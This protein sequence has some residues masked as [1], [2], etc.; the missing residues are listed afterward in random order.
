VKTLPLLQRYVGQVLGV[1]RLF[2]DHQPAVHSK[3]ESLLRVSAST[4][5]ETNPYLEP[6]VGPSLSPK[7]SREASP[8]PGEVVSAG[9]A[10]AP[11]GLFYFLDSN[12]EQADLLTKMLAAMDRPSACEAVNLQTNSQFQA[13]TQLNLI[14]GEAAYERLTN[15]MGPTYEQAYGIVQTFREKR[16]LTTSGP[17]ELLKDPA[18]KRA[19]W[20]HLKMF[21]QEMKS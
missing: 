17:A 13:G 21:M 19:T 3:V 16:W 6:N 5:Y 10:V 14:L 9:P 20:A 8:K 4:P 2:F 7:T 18:A 15:G 11:F 12:Q 1:E